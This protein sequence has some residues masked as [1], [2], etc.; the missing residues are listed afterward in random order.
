MSE[1]ERDRS[2]IDLTW[3]REKSPRGIVTGVVRRGRSRG[4]LLHTILLYRAYHNKQTVYIFK[5]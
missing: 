5:S 1:N 4:G 3:A 2:I